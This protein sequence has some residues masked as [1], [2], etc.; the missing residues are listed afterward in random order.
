M[1]LCKVEL[2]DIGDF[3][4]RQPLHCGQC[5]GQCLKILIQGHTQ[6][7][8]GDQAGGHIQSPA[9]GQ[10]LIGQPHVPLGA[11]HVLV[12]P[13]PA[14]AKHVRLGHENHGNTFEQ[15]LLD[16]RRQLEFDAGA[17]QQG[18]ARALYTQHGD[19]CRRRLCPC[20]CGPTR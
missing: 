3:P 16:R 20:W 1:A 19:F 18:V 10:R 5:V 13:V 17:E 9:P 12:G 8:I 11:H 6:P 4:A 15:R 7:G 2:R 14:F